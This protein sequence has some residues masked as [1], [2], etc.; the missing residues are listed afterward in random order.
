[1]IEKSPPNKNRGSKKL[2]WLLIGILLLCW[3]SVCCLAG[4]GLLLQKYLKSRKPS[5]LPTTAW[6]Q[7]PSCTVIPLHTPTPMERGTTS[8]TPAEQAS[9]PPAPLPFPL[10]TV[11]PDDAGYESVHAWE[12]AVVPT[13]DLRDLGLR[14]RPDWRAQLLAF[15]TPAAPTH[16]IGDDAKFWVF[17][18]NKEEHVQIHATL[19]YITP[20]V[21]FW[22]QNGLKISE[23]ALQQAAE[24]FET[25]IYPTD[26][27][28]FG[29][30]E[31][32]G[33]D[34]DVHLYF[35]ISD[36]LGDSL[37]G[38]FSGSDCFPRPANPYSNEKDM[39]FLNAQHLRLDSDLFLSTAAH[40]FQ[41]MIQ[42]NQDRNES[43]W[44]NEGLS[45]LA[46]R[47]NGFPPSFHV[48]SF[49]AEPD[50]PL[51]SWPD[52]KA[53][54]NY[55]AAELFT[56]YL[57]RH[58]GAHFIHQLARAPANGLLSVTDLLHKTYNSQMNANTLFAH[59][60]VANVLNNDTLDGGW[61]GY[62][63]PRIPT[64]E[65]STFTKIDRLPARRSSS[66][67]QYA[68][69]YF[70]LP[71]FQRITITFSG[72]TTNR[73]APLKAHDGHYVYWFNAD[74]D[75]AVS[76][77]RALDLRTVKQA[78]L[79]FWAWYNLENLWDFLYVSVSADGGQSWQ[80]LNNG[81][82][83]KENPYGN[84]LGVGFTGHSGNGDHM[85]WNLEHFNLS[86]W[87]G[88][89]IQLRFEYVT[90]DAVVHAGFFLDDV[91][92]PEIHFAD[93]FE[94]PV[95]DGW[96]VAGAVRTDI[97]VP[98]RYAVQVIRWDNRGVQVI[99]LPLSADQTGSLTI[100]AQGKG[101]AII[102]VSGIAPITREMAPYTLI[103]R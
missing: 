5:Y 7:T 102:V 97:L 100:T 18:D 39:F 26:H 91:S 75:S 3:L 87:A 6:R 34:G 59:W 25:K 36:Q 85:T 17:N 32:P 92:V 51:T 11:Q 84:N 95:T 31:L 24:T 71:T 76:M 54:A 79:H 74:D 82:T 58:F 30:E 47:V 44:L 64:V 38:Y 99:P 60:T 63:D 103:V 96:H 14:Y 61:Y 52:K 13:R 27:R 70:S 37:L 19:R 90:D 93:S 22:V 1:M 86:R 48:D 40:E 89:Q 69:D 50:T 88:K 66:V 62:H 41:H 20:H 72:Q 53:S 2:L 16:R 45:M 56:T 21:Y 81:D 23:N 4:E 94:K 65:P 73:I 35:L 33:I 80:M 78:H 101:K 57:Y 55:G 42:W 29:T 9:T 8:A 28:Y 12:N 15:A 68:T 43:T 67:H 98:Q 83:T 10:T 77:T 49:I 46:E